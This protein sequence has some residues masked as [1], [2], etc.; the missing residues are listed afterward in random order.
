MRICERRASYI[1]VRPLASRSGTRRDSHTEKEREKED[2]ASDRQRS[3]EVEKRLLT[4]SKPAMG[5]GSTLER[6]NQVFE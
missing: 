3:T 6:V 2:L 5:R 1:H 4:K